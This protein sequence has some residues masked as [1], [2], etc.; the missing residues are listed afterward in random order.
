MQGKKY[1]PIQMKRMIDDAM[2]TFMQK[3][4]NMTEQEFMTQ[5]NAALGGFKG[6]FNYLGHWEAFLFSE[7]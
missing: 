6:Q 5:R 3:I 4:D 1:D 2:F 7:V